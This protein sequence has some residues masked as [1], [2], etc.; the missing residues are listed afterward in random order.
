MAG[1]SGQAGDPASLIP[2]N[3]EQLYSTVAGLIR[4]AGLLTEAGNGLRQIDAGSG[5]SGAAAEAYHRAYQAQ[6]SR[7]LQAGDAFRA[8]AGALDGYAGVLR[9]A[10]QQA[11][12]AISMSQSGNPA[13]QIEAEQILTDARGQLDSAGSQAASAVS[14][15]AKLA[16]PA[17][18]FWSQIGSSIASTAVA[19]VSDPSGLGLAVAGAAIQAGS[20]AM[21]PSVAP[22]LIGMG[23]GGAV[24]NRGW[25]S[26]DH[27]EQ[28]DADGA[29]V[30]YSPPA[31]ASA[32]EMTERAGQLGFG[33]AVP[34][35]QA[36][37]DSH[38]QPVY[39]DGGGYITPD[40]DGWELLDQKGNRLG[41]YTWDL[42]WARK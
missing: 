18:G 8:A 21:A 12:T 28:A 3:P 6:P 37:F 41:S 40:G 34:P 32:Q 11:A 17:P 15:A 16:P 23:V 22:A 7:W 1:G 9:W 30:N 33:R 4:Y 31:P 39:T 42:T 35:Q 36:P 27:T 14:K 13:R 10:Q 26:I 29:G 25:Q 5:W 2:G 24:A 20:I 19:S 38:G